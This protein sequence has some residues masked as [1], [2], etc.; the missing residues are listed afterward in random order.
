MKR[1]KLTAG[2]ILGGIALIAVGLIVVDN[3]SGDSND[4]R[5]LV[6]L[7]E[8]TDNIWDE[9]ENN[10]NSPIN[11]SEAEGDDISQIAKDLT[12][13]GKPVTDPVKINDTSNIKPI[14]DVAKLPEPTE[15]SDTEQSTDLKPENM[16]A[17][18]SQE[19]VSVSSASGT[20]VTDKTEQATTGAAETTA[21]ENVQQTSTTVAEQVETADVAA[22]DNQSMEEALATAVAGAVENLAFNEA[23]GLSWPLEGDIMMKFSID[24]AIYHKTLCQ[25]KTNPALIIKAEIGDEVTAAADGIITS[26][27]NLPITGTT[28]KLAIGNGYELVYGQLEAD[29]W[30]AGEMVM[31]GEL[32][33]TVAKPTKYFSEEGANVYFQVMKNGEPTDP[34]ILLD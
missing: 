34:E 15:V 25:F 8:T 4:K 7:N 17:D 29:E 28:I 33:G 14:N 24:H 12:G 5:N 6:D 22:D 16:S 11:V 20:A 31:E 21:T 3:I 27:E 2:L 13:L 9:V 10:M 1:D 30:E 18:N 26:I 23:D 32:L 19:E